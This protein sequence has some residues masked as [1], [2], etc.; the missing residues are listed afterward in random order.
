MHCKYCGF[1][2]SADEHRCLRCGRRISGTAVSAPPGYA[3]NTA[4]ALS[5]DPNA[6]QDFVPAHAAGAASQT[7][8]FPTSE[9]KAGELKAAELRMSDQKVIPFD[10][11]Q[12]QVTGR[13]ALP[14]QPAVSAAPA[15]PQRPQARKIS[16]RN[17]AAQ[18][19][20][21]DFVQTAVAPPRTLKT[22]VPAQIYCD[23]PVAA[24]VHRLIAGGLDAAMVLIAFGLFVLAAHFMGGAFGEGKLLWMTLGGAFTLIALFYGLL[25]TLARRET[26]G[27]TWTGLQ[28]ITFD[29]QPVDAGA[30]FVRF[31]AVMLSFCSGGLGLIWAIADEENLTWHDHISKTFPTLRE[32]PRNFVRQRK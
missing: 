16:D 30:R 12:R 17:G 15:Q 14:S 8:L 25:W 27:M 19:A 6:T 31:F 28:V 22:D 4:L 20:S 21:L 2:N 32:I 5:M 24:P 23:L 26:A 3:G 9:F 10:Q 1:A 13:I 18:Q 29:G 11:L 7:P